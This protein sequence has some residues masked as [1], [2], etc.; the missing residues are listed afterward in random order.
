[1][2]HQQ[3][4]QQQKTRKKKYNQNLNQ[5]QIFSKKLLGKKKCKKKTIIN[6]FHSYKINTFKE[7]KIKR[8]IA[9]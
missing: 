3:Q 4:Q 7:I 6:Y 1:M 5:I 8:Y 2:Q 9:L